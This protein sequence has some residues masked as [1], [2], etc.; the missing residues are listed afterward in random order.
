MLI[1]KIAR[2]IAVLIFL[3]GVA[4]AQPPGPK[5]QVRTVTI[6]ISI[7]TKAELKENQVSE[8]VQMDRLVVQEDKDEQQVLSIR[9]VSD[10]PLSIAFIV[11]EDLAANFNLQI[12]DIQT[13]IRALPRGTRVMVAYSRAGSVQIRQRFTDNLEQA[14][15]A[16]RIVPGSPSSGPRSPYDA[17]DEVLSRFDGVPAGRRAILLFS[18]GLD[19]SQGANLASITQSFDLDQAVLK[20][21][22]KG[23]PIYSFYSPTVLIEREYSNFIFAA[24]GALNKIS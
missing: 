24:Q 17:V 18:D 4:S 1:G 9:S 20:A 21:Q 14:A 12:R 19:L 2:S 3:S 11:Q 15:T 6:P 23:V 13:F 8:F 7:F 16:L 10:A 22:R 5:Q